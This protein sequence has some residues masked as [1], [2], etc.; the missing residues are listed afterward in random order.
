MSVIIPC[1][2]AVAFISE[3]LKSLA[4]QTFTDWELIAIQDG[5]ADGTGQLIRRFAETVPQRVRYLSHVRNRGLPVAR[6]AA[7]AETSGSWIALLDADDLW[8]ANH[9]HDCMQRA[10]HGQA[11]I[12][13]GGSVL[14]EST[15]GCDIEMRIPGCDSLNNLPLSLLLNKLIIQPSALV[16][17]RSAF[18]RMG[19][20]D[21]SLRCVED[22]DFYLRALRLG[23]KIQYTGAVTCRYRKHR[24]GLSGKALI[25]ASSMAEVCAKQS[26]WTSIPEIVR[27]KRVGCAFESVGKIAFWSDPEFAGVQ[28]SRGWRSR[29]RRFRC[30]AKCML[31]R[32]WSLLKQVWR[33]SRLVRHESYDI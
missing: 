18:K 25:M 4:A 28:F 14:F 16:I 30:L 15:S 33:A 12:V 26:E 2:R 31:A 8:L 1:Y 19:G 17:R 11:D 3:T 32:V 24:D 23:V 29:H 5:D 20:F 6:N 21:T 9:L 13:F 27:A 7:F 10:K 22:L